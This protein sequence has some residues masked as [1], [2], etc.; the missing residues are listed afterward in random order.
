MVCTSRFPYLLR[1]SCT[2]YPLIPYL[3]RASHTFY[4]LPVTLTRFQYIFPASRTFY[5]GFLPCLS[6]SQ[7]FF[8][9]LLQNVLQCC[10]I[11]CTFCC[12]PPTSSLFSPLIER[13]THT[14]LFFHT[15]ASLPPPPPLHYISF[16]FPDNSHYFLPPHNVHVNTAFIAKKYA[17]Y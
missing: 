10:I 16:F 4:V 13:D 14:P 8:L 7:L 12:F 15:P 11:C 17:S 3:L 9:F 2:F 1:A 6:G 5:A